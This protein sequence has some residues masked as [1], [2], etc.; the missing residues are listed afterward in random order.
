MVADLHWG[1]CE[2]FRAHGAPLPQ[3]ILQA[4]L[5]RLALAL[6]ATGAERL[7]V[8]GDLLHAA[9]GITEWMVDTVSAWRR[10]RSSL[11]IVVVPG[12]HDRR[13]GMVAAPWAL[14][15]APAQLREGP[16]VFQHDPLDPVGPEHAG[17]YTWAGHYHPVV[18]LRGR[19]DHL[20]LP[21]F[22]LRE[23][24]GVLPAFSGFTSGAAIDPSGGDE[25]FAI[26]DNRVFRA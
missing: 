19:A 17:C 14:D 4:D 1:K 18:N 13:I 15:V 2:T 5:R 12:N 8:L 20:R 21:C 11:S 7:V 9:P 25:V 23:R 10:E 22:W 3:G 24:M 16:F 6:G 26:G